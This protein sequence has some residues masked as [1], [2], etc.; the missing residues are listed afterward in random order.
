MTEACAPG[1]RRRGRQEEP[2]LPARP[3][4]APPPGRAPAGRPGPVTLQQPSYLFIQ[5]EAVIDARGQSDQVSFLHENADPLVLRISHVEVPAAVQDVADLVVQVQ[6]LLVERL[7]LRTAGTATQSGRAGPH[8]SATAR[9]P[10]D[11]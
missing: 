3:T 9:A 6:V 2:A 8:G 1:S 11:P 7:P 4:W 10:R 5:R